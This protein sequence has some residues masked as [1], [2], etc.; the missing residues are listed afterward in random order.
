ML[1]RQGDAPWTYL[2]AA[3]KSALREQEPAV[4]LFVPL[5]RGSWVS[6]HPNP[7][8]KGEIRAN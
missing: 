5:T 8:A 1:S 7:R 3:L 6:V 2:I 4:S